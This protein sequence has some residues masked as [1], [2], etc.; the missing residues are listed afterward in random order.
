[1]NLCNYVES[2][3]STA[4]EQRRA[5]LARDKQMQKNLGG[6]GGTLPVFYFLI[7]DLEFWPCTVV[8]QT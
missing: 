4:S 2:L 8:A 1:M 6:G 7:A 5:S 3:K